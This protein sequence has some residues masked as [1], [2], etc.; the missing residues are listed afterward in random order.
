MLVKVKQRF[1]LSHFLL[2]L[3]LTRLSVVLGESKSNSEFRPKYDINSPNC[4]L[5][6]F[7]SRS[8]IVGG[9]ESRAGDWGWQVNDYASL[10]S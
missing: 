4:G 7:G 10:Y 8:K 1:K 3:F 5:R 9:S 6:P 2:G